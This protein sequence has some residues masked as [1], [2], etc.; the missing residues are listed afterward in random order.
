MYFAN[1]QSISRIT[2]NRRGSRC[3]FARDKHATLSISIL[4]P[5]QGAALRIAEAFLESAADARFVALP[6]AMVRV[7]ALQAAAN[8]LVFDVL[9]VRVRFSVMHL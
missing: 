9:M 2:A 8:A 5:Y 6:A 3:C 7:S 4:L 1:A